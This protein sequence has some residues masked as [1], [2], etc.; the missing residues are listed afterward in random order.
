MGKR[1]GKLEQIGI[2]ID[3]RRLHGRDIMGAEYLANDIQ[4]AR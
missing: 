1:R 2:N 3:T 4:A